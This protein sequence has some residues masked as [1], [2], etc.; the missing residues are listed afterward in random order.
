MRRHLQVL[1][2]L[3]L[4][5]VSFLMPVNAFALAPEVVQHLKRGTVLVQTEKSE[6]SGFFVEQNLVVTNRHVVEGLTD[7]LVQVVLDSGTRDAQVVVAY[8][9]FEHPD[10]D[11]AFLYVEQEQD[12]SLRLGERPVHE[13]QEVVAVG[14][15]MGSARSF[16][17]EASTLPCSLRPGSITALYQDS[18]G[19]TRLLEHNANMQ[20]GNSGGPL[21]D[22]LGFVVGV[23][24]FIMRADETTKY[25]IPTN[26][27]Q[28]A[29]TDFLARIEAQLQAEQAVAAA[30]TSPQAPTQPSPVIQTAIAEP[31]E[32]GL[33]ADVVPGPGN[34]NYV[35]LNSGKIWELKDERRWIRL[36][37]PSPLASVAFDPASRR[38]Y[39]STKQEGELLVWVEEKFDWE[40]LG[41]TGVQEVDVMDGELW[42]VGGDGDVGRLGSSGKLR[43]L[44]LTNVERLVLC[45][46]FAIMQSGD[47]LW[48]HD[49][50]KLLENGETVDSGVRDFACGAGQI[51]RLG[52]DGVIEDIVSEEVL[53]RD[54]NNQR[55]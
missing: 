13:T 16:G 7:K 50:T 28:A 4:F 9:F 1:P 2:L 42:L 39:A 43:M 21:V 30:P 45:N 8:V 32:K 15:P 35:L 23:N 14:Y 26:A 24:T 12:R 52:I 55:L 33:V 37:A 20:T 41:F 49:G 3:L 10:I 22:D 27:L 25:A 31:F 53:D 44:G 48:L 40:S 18:V 6:G 51:F 19:G 38:L 17:G 47:R 5:A 11:L 46:G 54:P 36:Y 34:N 29:F